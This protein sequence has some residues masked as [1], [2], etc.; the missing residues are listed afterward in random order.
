MWSIGAIATA[1][2]TGDVIFTDRINPTMKYDP[3]SV[4]LGLSSK[5][6]LS[7][8]DDPY[9]IWRTVGKRPKDFIKKLLVLDEATR[10]DVKQALAHEWFTSKVYAKE[11][12]A[13]YERSIQSWQSHRKIL[14][15]VE[16][17]D[18]KRLKTV[19]QEEKKK[20]ESKSRFFSQM[21]F[22]FPQGELR[23][24]VHTPTKISHA[25]LPTIGEESTPEPEAFMQSLP[26]VPMAPKGKKSGRS[27]T[28]FDMQYSLSQLD[29]DHNADAS[30][31]TTDIQ[32]TEAD[33]TPSGNYNL[34]AG[35]PTHSGRMPPPRGSRHD[36]AEVAVLG[37]PPAERKRPHS[38]SV[39]DDDTYDDTIDSMGHGFE[40]AAYMN[41][42][43]KVRVY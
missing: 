24:Q 19:L 30:E 23:G 35:T 33:D 1:L 3:H 18:M 9:S 41:G 43:K 16:A 4:I 25:P 12:N 29:L 34:D 38:P 13:M 40:G 26:E 5:C 15:L 21:S 6:D 32:M 37:T 28:P 14:R 7:V 10:L 20:E 39:Q 36:K 2:L 27:A 17:L 11:L 8:L 42:A 22:P 31:A